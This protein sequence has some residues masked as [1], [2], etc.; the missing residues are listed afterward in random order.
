MADGR[1]HRGIGLHRR[2]AAA[3]RAPR[4]PELEVALRHRRHARPARRVAE[5]YP[6]LAAAYPRPGVRRRSTRP[7]LDGLDLVFLRP[8]PRRLPGAR[9]RPARAGAARSSTWPPT[10][11]CRTRALPARG[12]ARPTPRPSCWP[13]SPTACPSCSAT[14]SRAR[15]PSPRPAATPPPPRWPWRRCVRRGL[16]EPTGIVVD[17]ASGV[18]GA[19]RPPKPNTTFCTV[20]EDFTAYGLLDHRHT[21]EIEQASSRRR[22]VLFTPHL[23]PMNRGILATCYARPDRRRPP[24][25]TLLDAA[26]TTPTPT[27][28]SWSSPTARRRPRPRSAPTPPTSPSGP[29]PAP[30]GSSPSPP[31]TTWSR[32]RRARPSS[33]PTSLLGLD[34]TTGLPIVGVYP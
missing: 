34:E 20:D 33:A 1:H 8:A 7:R 17:A 12:T 6:S 11:G 18:S 27:S 23:A 14:S 24:P 26:R 10:S 29:T 22:Q 21:P 19:G 28:R 4:H 16:V 30:A 31:S 32:A 9:A 5:L 2:R 3:P 15:P 13:S 25:P